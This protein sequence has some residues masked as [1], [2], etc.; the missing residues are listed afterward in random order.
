MSEIVRENQVIAPRVQR[1]AWAEEGFHKFRGQ[2]GTAAGTGPVKN[3]H[4]IVD[5]AIRVPRGIAE[6]SVMQAKTSQGLA[7]SERIVVVVG[8]YA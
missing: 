3:Q 1:P 7:V 8:S 6:R 5:V 4:G 2:K